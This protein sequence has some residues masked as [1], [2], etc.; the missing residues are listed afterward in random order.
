[1]LSLERSVSENSGSQGS[2]DVFL[3]EHHVVQNIFLPLSEEFAA[4]LSPYSRPYP[5]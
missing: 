5:F 2:G 1:M 4:P 3:P